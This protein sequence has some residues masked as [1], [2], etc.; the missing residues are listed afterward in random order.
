MYAYFTIP[1]VNDFNFLHFLYDWL[2]E[3]FSSSNICKGNPC[4]LCWPQ[5]P[6]AQCNPI[7]HGTYQN[8][9]LRNV[10]IHNP[11]G[12]PGVILADASN[13]IDTITFD[14]V[15]VTSGGTISSSLSEFNGRDV[16]GLFRGLDQPIDDHKSWFYSF[17]F[18]LFILLS[19]FILMAGLLIYGVAKCSRNYLAAPIKSQNDSCNDNE[20]IDHFMKRKLSDDNDVVLNMIKRGN[21]RPVL[22]CHRI[23]RRFMQALICIMNIILLYTIHKTLMALADRSNQSHFFVCRGVINGVALADTWPIPHCFTD[24]TT[25]GRA[26]IINFWLSRKTLIL[27]LEMSCLALLFIF[28]RFQRLSSRNSYDKAKLLS[29]HDLGKGNRNRERTS[30]DATNQVSDSDTDA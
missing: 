17:Y 3:S 14:N 2:N 10:I 18:Y 15:T 27:Y 25:G 20:D 21:R 6:L 4:S 22:R 24:K 5:L 23:I 26:Q 16:R 7:K 28:P 12:S 11:R 19:T 8:I 29:R 13:P 9:T 30:T 1:Q